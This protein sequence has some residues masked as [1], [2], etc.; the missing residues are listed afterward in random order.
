MDLSLSKLQGKV[1]E[2][3]A[4]IAAVREVTETDTTQPLNN[5]IIYVIS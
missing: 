4:W 5:N 3:E 2:R 1:K